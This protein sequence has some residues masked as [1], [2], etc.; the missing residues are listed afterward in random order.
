MKVMGNV[1]AAAAALSVW[2]AA[3]CVPAAQ[4]S[5]RERI[6]EL[7]RQVGI[8]AEEI[9][10]LKLGGVAGDTYE[11]FSGLGPAASK[12]YGV[13]S[14]L[15]V[16][17]YGEIVYSDYRHGSQKDMVDVTRLILYTGYKFSDSIVMNTEFEYEHAGVG[18]VDDKEP[19]VYV[20][21]SYLDFLLSDAFN[22]RAGLILVPVGIINEYHEPTVYNGSIRPDLESLVIP[23]TWRE[24]GVMAHG[25]VGRLS[26]KAAVLN[27]LRSDLFKT[28]SWIKKGRQK[29][30]KANAEPAAGLVRLDY[31]VGGGLIVGGSYY[32]SRAEAGAGGS[33]DLAASQAEGTVKLWEAHGEFRKGALM[34]R[35]IYV[36]GRTGGN[37]AFEA[38]GVGKS[39]GGW[40]AEAAYD[41]APV[42]GLG[43]DVSVTPFVRYE[44]YD[45]NREVFSGVSRNP[46]Y[47]RE[48]LTVGVGYK[49]HPNVVVKADYQA[50]DTAS[51]LPEGKGPGLDS[52]KVDR[53]NLAVGFIF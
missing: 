47:D 50:R 10:N 43:A 8:L 44:S 26:Y 34:L 27:G 40:Y 33:S 3:T 19:E 36:D 32:Y 16:G 37:S 13:D 28:S 21:F 39:A 12:V 23:S 15:S 31:E 48:V 42:L 4:A 49:P 5:D 14:G 7:E 30:A 20:E 25:A 2:I 6:N 1:K 41:A 53:F 52:G 24:F 38:T 11:S 9:E 18:N 35:A 46:A 22:V 29:G 17:G 51:A 45:T